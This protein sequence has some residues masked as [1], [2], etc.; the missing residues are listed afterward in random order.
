MIKSEK[1]LSD[2]LET[3]R[4]NFQHF[5]KQGLNEELEKINYINHYN[6][7]IKMDPKKLKFKKPRNSVEECITKS[8]TYSI[9][10]YIP[11]EIKYKQKTI[12]KNKYLFWGEIPFMTEKGTFVINGNSRIILNQII[13]SPGI[14]FEQNTNEKSVTA[15]IIPN[16]GSWITIKTDERG[17][18]FAKIDRQKKLPIIT[19]L[20]AIGFS[21]KKILSSIKNTEFI[22]TYQNKEKDTAKNKN[23]KLKKQEITEV[24]LKSNIKKL[25][26]KL[27]KKTK[28]D[29]GETGRNK[30]N[31]KL[32]KENFWKQGK[33]LRPEDILG[34]LHHLI[35]LKEGLDTTDDIDD[36]KNKRIRQCGEL[37]QNQLKAN[38][39][40]IT[41]SIKEK[42]EDLEKKIKDGKIEINTN[43]FINYYIL[44]NSF[45][46]FFTSN[47]LSQ[48]ME[49]TNPLA[50]I[51]HKRKIS[52]F[53]I[54]AIDR[55][56]ANLNIR[57][58]HPSQ[59]G[60]ICPI[61]TTEGKNAGLILSL[62]K[63]TRIN[64]HGFIESPFY[65]IFKRK[66][67]YKIGTFFINAEQEK[68]LIFAAGDSINKMSKAKPKEIL[69]IRKNQEFSEG[70]TAKVD[71]ISISPN[72]ITSVGT[73]LIPFLEHNDANRALMGSNMQRQA[74]PLIYKEK[75]LVKTGIENRIA[76]DSESSIILRKSGL[77][78]HA[79]NKKI[80]IFETKKG[81]FNGK[82]T[83]KKKTFLNKLKQKIYKK[84]I[85]RKTL[86]RTYKLD[87]EKRSNQ[88]TQ[89]KQTH[90]LKKTEWGRKGQVLAEGT[91]SFKGELSLGKNILIAYMTWEGYNFED[92]IV[93]SERL[94]NDELYDSIHIK[95][96]KTYIINKETE[97]ERITKFI[98]NATLQTI[99][100]LKK[101]GIIKIGSC[102]ENETILIGKTRK[103]KT[104]D[105][106]TKLLTTI[107]RREIIKD[108]SLKTPKGIKGTVTNIKILKKKDYYSIIIFINER[109]KIQLGDKVAGRHGNKG[110]ISK[111]LPVEDMPYTQDG[112]GID[113]LLNP[114]GI[115]SR[116]NVGQILECLLGLA[117]KNLKEEYKITPF[118]EKLNENNST[119][120]VY[121]KLYEARKKTGKEWLFIPNNPG[122]S[123]ILDGRNGEVFKQPV[124]IGYSYMLKLMH[125]V[126]DKINARLTGPYTLILKQPIRGKSKRGGQRFGEMEVWA[127]EGF[128][129]AYTLQELLTIKSDDLTNR[130]KTLIAIMKGRELPEPSAPESLKT[131]ILELQC[132][133][134]KL[135][136][137]KGLKQNFF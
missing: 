40:E 23:Y 66:V 77:I 36:L 57:E 137:F 108:V 107:F 97:E 5:I 32:Y 60:R 11:V 131:L 62:A 20:E 79:T 72:Q 25:I 122:K 75:P 16:Q 109:R 43:E 52:S 118:E 100:N 15:T 87:K 119:Q 102:I 113:M 136:I 106:K 93:I 115:P 86:I 53:G 78:I 74:V 67:N 6:F 63:D 94:I 21:R 14:Y 64:R 12:F 70:K 110:I 56:K 114:L 133:C 127:L 49:E 69:S 34:S 128:G 59:Y 24:K 29:L 81:N 132:L 105:I 9:P 61:E 55:K 101:N 130:S 134:L 28:Y 65:K 39:T 19:L 42:I 8:K 88:N 10:L 92:A 30:I 38:L 84:N 135:E 33:T 99:K 129:C 96:Y 98:P 103:K 90:C 126:E 91:G 117:A 125:L 82:T 13:R 71:F 31:K 27:F 68:K 112:T 41:K 7:E 111:I 80:T 22:Q 2:L 89:S 3:Q 48:L 73:G 124:T 104:L 44:T 76:K 58:I 1:I 18:T 121:N 85:F 37:M 4:L 35:K 17:Y 83:N 116:M 50:E 120:I 51:T 26:N 54:G 46:K 95:K 123:K 45:K 47:Q